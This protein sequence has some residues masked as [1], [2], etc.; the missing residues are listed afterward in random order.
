VSREGASY[1]IRVKGR[2]SDSLMAAFEGMRASVEPVETVIHGPVLDQA[3]LCGLL[4]RIQALGLELVEVRRLPD[5]PEEEEQALTPSRW[6]VTG[7]PPRDAAS[8]H[9]GGPRHGCRRPAMELDQGQHHQQ[10]QGEGARPWWA[11]SEHQGQAGQDDGTDL[12]PRRQAVDHLVVRPGVKVGEHL[13]GD[14]VGDGLLEGR[15]GTAGL[16]WPRTGRCCDLVAV[17]GHHR[18]RGE[19]SRA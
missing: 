5:P 2:L 11:G 13:G 9:W 15:V 19:R 3:A 14:P 10:G 7:R 1:E 18:R 12:R 16:P 8:L 17:D 4:D 6:R